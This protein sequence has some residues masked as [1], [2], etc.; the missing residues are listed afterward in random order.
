MYIF[1]VDITSTHH[2]L[3]I[4]DACDVHDFF[5]DCDLCEECDVYVVLDDCV[6][7]VCD[8]RDVCEICDFSEIH[9][10]FNTHD[11]MRPI[12][13][14][15]SMMFLMILLP[16]IHSHLQYIHNFNDVLHRCL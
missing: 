5:D 9:D 2:G 3:D 16:V 12:I 10:D 7:D 8:F 6:T 15:V 1:S 14:L 13:Y 4:C 11:F